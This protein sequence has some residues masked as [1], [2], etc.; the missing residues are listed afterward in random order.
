MAAMTSITTVPR[1]PIR[2]DRNADLGAK[3][4]RRAPGAVETLVARYGDLLY[5]L[6]VELTGNEDDAEKIVQ[7]TLC[8][9]VYRIESFPGES[10]LGSWLYRIAAIAASAARRRRHARQ[11]VSWDEVIAA[12]VASLAGV[13]GAQPTRQAG[14]ALDQQRQDVDRQRSDWTRK[15]KGQGRVLTQQ[16]SGRA[17]TPPQHASAAAFTRT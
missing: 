1:A 10:A 14:V 16:D 17:T 13:T 11:H 4:R 2:P 9:A 3:L 5:R 12:L 7:D 15:I 8:A 6:A